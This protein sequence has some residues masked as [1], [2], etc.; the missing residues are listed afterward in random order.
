MHVNKISVSADAR[1]M[2]TNCQIFLHVTL[3]LSGYTTRLCH[4]TEWLNT[5]KGTLKQ[6]QT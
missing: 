2:L 1:T 3:L 4:S 5:K 6:S